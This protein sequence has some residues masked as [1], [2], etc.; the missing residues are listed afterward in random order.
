MHWLLLC[1]EPW[2]RLDNLIL[3]AL[4]VLARLLVKILEL[5]LKYAQVTGGGLA[6]TVQGSEYC[7]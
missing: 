2:V 3:L 4:V 6:V 7:S 5:Q 1:P